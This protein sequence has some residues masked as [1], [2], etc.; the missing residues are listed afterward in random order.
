MKSLL[1]HSTDTAELLARVADEFLQA[2]DGGQNPDVEEFAARYP[3][4]AGILRDVLPALTLMNPSHS[5][6]NGAS[7]PS[8]RGEGRVSA[9]DS[10]GR[11]EGASPSS[12]LSGSSR[13]DAE[14]ET[15]LLGDFRLIREI[16]RC[17]MGVVYEAEQISLGRTVALKVLPFAAMLDQRQL[18]RFR[19]EARAAAALHHHNIVPVF[20]VG[21]ERGVHYYAM[22]FIDGESLAAVIENIR[23]QAQ[24][25]GSR[26]QTRRRKVIRPFPIPHSPLPILH[27]PFTRSPLHPLIRR[28]PLAP[29]VL[30]KLTTHCSPLTRRSSPRPVRPPTASTSAPSPNWAS[31][32]PRHSIMPTSK[33]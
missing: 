1:D 15:G 27:H 10:P 3:Q 4:I 8:P 31:K 7:A 32:P 28:V 11:G 6:S 13:D 17:G 14:I 12:P 25:V 26:V 5:R 24:G 23:E 21:C 33:A 18:T 20:S 9:G 22:Q 30:P 16:G 29:P 2:V 19:N